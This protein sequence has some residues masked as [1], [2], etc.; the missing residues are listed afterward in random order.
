MPIS[1]GSP[2][3]LPYFLGPNNH[4]NDDSNGKYFVNN[5][6]CQ[7]LW[8][9]PSSAHILN[10][11]SLQGRLRHNIEAGRKDVVV[12]DGD[13]DDEVYVFNRHYYALPLFVRGP[14]IRLWQYCCP[15]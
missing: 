10:E 8:V 14:N 1:L 11:T 5:Y 3:T 15:E 7:F 2:F 12:V 9:P 4:Y 13:N 6:R